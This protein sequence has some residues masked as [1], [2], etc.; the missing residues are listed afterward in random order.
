MAVHDLFNL[1]DDKEKFIILFM[2]FVIIW[3]SATTCQ[4]F[5]QWNPQSAVLGTLTAFYL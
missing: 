5:N 4:F 2:R 3:H 1:L